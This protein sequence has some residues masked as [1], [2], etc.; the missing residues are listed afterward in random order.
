[1]EQHY[2]KRSLRRRKVGPRIWGE[3][4]L[5]HQPKDLLL[6]QGPPTKD[7]PPLRAGREVATPPLPQT[8]S[9]PWRC[10]ERESGGEPH[11]KEEARDEDLSQSHGAKLRIEAMPQGRR[12]RERGR[13]TCELCGAQQWIKQSRRHDATETFPI[14]S[15]KVDM[16]IR[17]T[18]SRCNCYLERKNRKHSEA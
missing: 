11:G 12:E 17:L 6:R 2:P 16:K 7:P 8:E 10:R 3:V 5:L 14:T 4:P 9:N 15:Y 18:H 1:M 13:R